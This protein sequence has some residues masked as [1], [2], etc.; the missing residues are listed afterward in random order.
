M[1][2]EPRVSVVPDQVR[3]AGPQI[4]RIAAMG[5]IRLDETQQ[6]AVNAIGGVGAD[7]KWAAYESVLYAPRQNIKTQ[8]LIARILFGLFV[9]REKSQIYS[10]HEVK[11][12]TKTF[13][14]LKLCIDRSP[15]LGGRIARVSNRLGSETIELTTGQ[16][17]E[18][19]ARSTS[20]G[21][22][23]TASTLYLDEAHAVDGDQLAAQLPALA[24]AVNPQVIYA[25]SLADER[26]LHLAGLRERALAGKPGVCWLGWNMLEGEDVA[27]RLAVGCV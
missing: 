13:K 23:F 17:L 2:C 19:V 9:A 11:T 20:S 22:G 14:R 3:S 7:R 16:T 15:R 18:C 12:A 27:D 5:G 24:T 21:R 4:V 6:L 8:I 10:A 1:L 25:A 26:S